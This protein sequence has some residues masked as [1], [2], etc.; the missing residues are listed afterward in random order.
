MVSFTANLIVK[1]ELALERE[2][3]TEASGLLKSD[4]LSLSFSGHFN[5]V[6]IA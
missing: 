5:K 3:D 4:N 1:P 6:Y 2:T